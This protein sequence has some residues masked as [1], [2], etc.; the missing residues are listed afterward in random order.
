M[1]HIQ[2]N[3]GVC[4]PTP[5]KC[6][7]NALISSIRKKSVKS[8]YIMAPGHQVHAVKDGGGPLARIHILR[9]IGLLEA[10]EDKIRKIRP[11]GTQVIMLYVPREPIRP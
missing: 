9:H 6:K 11:K 10:D 2:T 3:G 1:S 7:T 5:K 4:F 8:A